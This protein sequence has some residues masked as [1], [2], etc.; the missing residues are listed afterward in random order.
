MK[1]LADKSLKFITISDFVA[2][3]EDIR[4]VFNPS[5]TIWVNTIIKSSYEDTNKIFQNPSKYNIEVTSK[6]AI[7]W[8]N[9]IYNDLLL[10]IIL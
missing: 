10:K 2:P 3:T 5:Y 4:N 9:V 6:D 7:Y 8:S 1:S